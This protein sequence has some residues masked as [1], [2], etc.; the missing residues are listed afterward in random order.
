MRSGQSRWFP[1][2]GIPR[3]KALI[4]VSIMELLPEANRFASIFG[5][6][7]FD[8]EI[9]AIKL[10]GQMVTVLKDVSQ[11]EY[12]DNALI[13]MYIGHGCDERIWISNEE[14]KRICEIVDIFS[15]NNCHDTFDRKPKIFIFNCC[16]HNNMMA[17]PMATNINTEQ[18]LLV[19]DMSSIDTNWYNQNTR[20][21]ICY[22]CVETLEELGQRPEIRQFMVTRD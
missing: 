9:H 10:C 6:L 3:G 16:R 11:K 20:T 12:P 14:Q 22:S 7:Y 4:F 15:G 18:R 5:Q 17:T 2:D 21:Y 1:M 13:V 19:F 8:V